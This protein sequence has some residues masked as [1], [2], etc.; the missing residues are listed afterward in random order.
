ML[1]CK[2]LK[3]CLTLNFAIEFKNYIEIKQNNKGKSSN[4]KVYIFDEEKKKNYFQT[5]NFLG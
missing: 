2:C 5:I 3:Q 4:G 1:P